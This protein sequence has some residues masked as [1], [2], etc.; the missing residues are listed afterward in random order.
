MSVTFNMCREIHA[1]RTV[2]S[3][4]T[5]LIPYFLWCLH[6]NLFGAFVLLLFSSCTHSARNIR[7]MCSLLICLHPGVHFPVFR[8]LAPANL[9]GITT[10]S[11]LA[12]RVVCLVWLC[13]DACGHRL[14]HC[15]LKD[16]FLMS[17]TPKEMLC[18]YIFIH[19]VEDAKTWKHIHAWNGQDKTCSYMCSYS[20]SGYVFMCSGRRTSHTCI[21]TWKPT[22]TTALF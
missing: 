12:H 6:G 1:W 19:P 8:P 13:S 16:F 15:H 11:I 22:H 21:Y 2:S 7:R 10:K 20:I 18:R 5:L 17:H 3:I 9:A 4:S 14:S